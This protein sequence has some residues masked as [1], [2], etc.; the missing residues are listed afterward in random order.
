MSRTFQPGEIPADTLPASAIGD[1]LGLENQ[2]CFAFYAAAHA[3]TNAYRALLGPLGL[4]YPQYL[5][6]LVL[7]E[8]D[9]QSVGEL[10]AR[11]RLDSGTLTPMLKRLEA[12]GLVSRARRPRDERMVEIRL[13]ESGRALRDQ[14]IGVRANI[15]CQLGMTESEIRALRGRLDGVIAALDEY[16][17]APREIGADRV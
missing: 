3:M 1:L 14:G 4:T 17:A 9:G 5:A 11:L 12:A 2:L 10:G 16:A 13:T 7:W 15:V 8:K 6:L